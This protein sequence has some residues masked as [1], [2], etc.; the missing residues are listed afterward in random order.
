V[1]GKNAESELREALEKVT[2]QNENFDC[3]VVVRGGGARLDLAAFDGLE[4]S[5]TVANFPLPVFTGIGHDMDETVL[6]LVAHTALKTP[7][8]VAD[9][10][11]QHNLIFEN[12]IFEL[13]ENLRAASDFR[14][15]INQL[16]LERLETAAH[17][18]C[19]ERLRAA[20]R[21]LDILEENLPALG[22][23]LLRNQS[24]FLERAEVICRALEPESILRRGYSLTFKNGK[25]VLS[26]SEVA[27]G[28]LLET[29]LREGS[30]HSVVKHT[31]T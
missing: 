2:L 13:A 19:R 7:T 16:E 9:F 17:F 8:A 23:Q 4:L 28:D 3:A 30:L 11:L 15:K 14:L 18:G 25:A 29:R 21:R 12:R 20:A 22:F 10:L 6:D 24:R 5:K 31:G 27:A 26:A 1:Q